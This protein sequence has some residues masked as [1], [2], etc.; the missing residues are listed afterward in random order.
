MELLILLMLNST[1]E[2][3]GAEYIQ[4][5]REKRLDALMRTQSEEYAQRKYMQCLEDE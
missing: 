5:C 3:S 1:A 4:Y 2:M